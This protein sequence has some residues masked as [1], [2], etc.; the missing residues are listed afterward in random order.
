MALARWPRTRIDKQR[1]VI[2]ADG[3]L[4]VDYALYDG[5]LGGIVTEGVE[6]RSEREADKFEPRHGSART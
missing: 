6:F 5:E 2:P 1:F 3:D 4:E